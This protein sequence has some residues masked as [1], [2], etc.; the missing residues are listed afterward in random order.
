MQVDADTITGIVGDDDDSNIGK[1]PDAIA[2][3]SGVQE[4]YLISQDQSKRFFVRRAFIDSGDWNRDEVISGDT[5]KRY[6]LQ[7]LELKSFDAGN[8]HDLDADTSSGVYNSV[9]DTRACNYA[10]GFLCNG[11]GVGDVLYS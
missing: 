7:S 8:M 9:L 1:G 10:G 2:Q 11:Q 4:L 6:S 3:T 5:E